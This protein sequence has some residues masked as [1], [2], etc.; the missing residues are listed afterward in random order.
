MQKT[1]DKNAERANGI[2]NQILK[3]TGQI[4]DHEPKRNSKKYFSQIF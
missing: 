2:P 3:K 1:V 4:S